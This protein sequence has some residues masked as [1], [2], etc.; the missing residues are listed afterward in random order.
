MKNNNNSNNNN[1]NLYNNNNNNLY[2][3]KI[4]V[5]IYTIQNQTMNINTNKITYLTNP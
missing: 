2:N 1:N 5:N 4:K 3:N